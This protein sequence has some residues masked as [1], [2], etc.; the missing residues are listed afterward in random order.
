MRTLQ[1]DETTDV[2]TDPTTGQP[3]GR[4][5]LWTPG[6]SDYGSLSAALMALPGQWT[7]RQAQ[8]QLGKS[9]VGSISALA[10]HLCTQ[11][12]IRRL[13]RGGQDHRPAVYAAKPV[14]KPVAKTAAK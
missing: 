9:S 8:Q 1:L 10:S 5:Y 14:A 11:G 6:R 2:L 4:A 12:R 3:V 13:R 7:P